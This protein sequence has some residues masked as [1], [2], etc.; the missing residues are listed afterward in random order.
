MLRKLSSI[1]IPVHCIRLH[2]HP[3][4]LES[5]ATSVSGGDSA[6]MRFASKVLQIIDYQIPHRTAQTRH[7]HAERL[8]KAG[9]GQAIWNVQRRPP[10]RQA[11]TS[12][13]KGPRYSVERSSLVAP[14]MRALLLSRWVSSTNY[15]LRVYSVLF[16]ASTS[17]VR[18]TT[19]IFTPDVA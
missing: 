15:V 9:L 18:V 8:R 3:A 5:A 11:S 14:L 2:S 16:I 10:K 7:R 13:I 4:K 12:I 1:V 6:R 19:K 17:I